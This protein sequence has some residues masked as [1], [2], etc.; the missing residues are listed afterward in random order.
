M[1]IVG[2]FFTFMLK[3]KYG[4]IQKAFKNKDSKERMDL[5]ATLASFLTKVGA[6]AVVTLFIYEVF[7]YNN[8]GRFLTLEEFESSDIVRYEMFFA[9]IFILIIFYVFR[10]ISKL[11]HSER[12]EGLHPVFKVFLEVISI[13]LATIV[14]VSLVNYIPLML[15]FPDVTPNPERY[16]TGYIVT[17]I[18][19]L[20]FYFLIE[21]ERFQKQL[22][23]E[24]LRSAKLEKEN[25]KA[26]LEGLKQQVNPHFLFN[27]LNVLR[28]LVYSDQDKAV[29]FI[30]ELSDLYRAFLNNSGESL[31]PLRKEINLVKSYIFL[32]KTRFGTNIK[33]SIEVNNKTLN[34]LIPPG[35]LQ[36]LIEN[37]V[38]HN[39]STS[40]KPLM[41]K[42]FAKNSH[43]T[44]K[45]NI[46]PR[47]EQMV[48]TKTGLKNIIKRYG[49][50]TEDQVLIEKEDN[51]FIVSLP[52]L[53]MKA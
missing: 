1:C 38:K 8:L 37:A 27:S 5:K 32:V 29:H 34:L 2:N 50:L 30:S 4:D 12:F 7:F 11:M 51:E 36:I 49:F 20:L 3:R 45:N 46:A 6:A 42:I 39:G 24:I 26:Q 23:N 21:R 18:F 44:V 25:Y 13:V 41:I 31:I 10:W 43:I 47:K 33:F 9:F 48:S 35:C 14:L 17:S 22:Q 15:I 16:R 28:S 40:K 53:K 52:L 19:S